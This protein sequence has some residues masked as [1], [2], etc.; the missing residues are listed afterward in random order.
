MNEDIKECIQKCETCRT[1]EKAQQK[2][3]LK[4]HV[5]AEQPWSTVGVDLFDLGENKYVVRIQPLGKRKLLWKKGIVK[6]QVG[7]R[8]YEVVI[9]DGGKYRRNR[10]HL[11]KTK[12]PFIAEYE[13]VQNTTVE[14]AISEQAV[15]NPEPVIPLGNNTIDAE[16]QNADNLIPPRDEESPNRLE[17]TSGCQEI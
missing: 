7:E 17:K 11:K 9:R 10:R 16:P 2:E 14:A 3:T 8:S 4:Q 15:Q 1:Y 13:P 6:R 12:E 5:T